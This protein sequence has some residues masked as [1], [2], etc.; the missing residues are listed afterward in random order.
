MRLWRT[1][2]RS[3]N[4][5]AAHLA[6]LLFALVAVGSVLPDQ[7]RAA[8]GSDV[9]IV[10]VPAGTTIDRIAAIEGMA[11]GLVNSSIGPVDIRQK[12]LDISQGN[13]VPASVYG[14]PLPHFWPTPGSPIAPEDWD[15]VVE[16]AERAP[17]RLVP[18]LF[19]ATLTENRVFAGATRESSIAALMVVDTDGFVPAESS[20][21]GKCADCPRVLVDGVWPSELVHL[22]ADA[23]ESGELLIVIE[24][25]R[26]NVA[27]RAIGIVG[28][29]FGGELTSGTTRTGGIVAA[30]DIAPTVL[31]HFGIEVPREMN[32]RVIT[33]SATAAEIESGA[34]EGPD[35]ARLVVLKERFETKSSR[36][37]QIVDLTVLAWMLVAAGVAAVGRRPAARWSVP[38]LSLSV[39]FLPLAV[40]LVGATRP[41]MTVEWIAVAVG[42]PLV[43]LAIFALLRD[44]RAVAVPCLA[45]VAVLALDMIFGLG[46]VVGSVIGTSPVSGGRFF[47]LDNSYEIVVACLLP[48]GLGALM[49]SRPSTRNGGQLCAALFVG[50]ILAATVPFALGRFGADVGAAIVLPAAAITAAAVA[51]RSKR[52]AL[53]ALVAPIIGLLALVLA[54]LVLGTRSHLVSSVVDIESFSD[55]VDVIE[56]KASQAGT[57]FTRKSNVVAL[58][59]VILAV[60]LGIWQ[61][62]RVIGWFTSRAALAGFTGAIAATIVGT[63]AND[64]GALLL[65]YGTAFSAAAAGFAWAQSAGPPRYAGRN[66]G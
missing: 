62:R 45:T 57:S 56:R 36:R 7:T 49:A 9:R 30:T 12:Y 14:Q 40:L 33:A 13:R 32:G 63:I 38:I 41:S 58:P 27:F 23:R 3:P 1:A 50:V 15:L 34:A 46:L 24:R 17:G 52:V 37:T 54:D 31:D 8:D 28:A 47:G 16:R 42:A 19:A 44:W 53:L 55:L 51:L 35:L 26:P 20:P 4:V 59:F 48:I 39:M 65:I 43:S 61:W 29:G 22:A 64:S 10:M 60:G 5:L 66:S 21:R 11:V 25:F 2:P 18:G 6:V